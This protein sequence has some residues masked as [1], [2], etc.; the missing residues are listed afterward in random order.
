MHN[1]YIYIYFYF[2]NILLSLLHVSIHC[3]ILREFQSC[4]SP[5]LHSFSI[6]KIPLQ[7][8]KLIYIYIYVVFFIK[9]SQYDFYN[10]ICISVMFT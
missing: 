2:N 3:I 1:I 7:I 6:I 5:K 10:I 8:I 9:C 4:T